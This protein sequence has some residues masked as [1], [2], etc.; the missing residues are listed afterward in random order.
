M[1]APNVFVSIEYT[2]CGNDSIIIN[3]TAY[4]NAGIYYDTISASI[5]CDTVFENII[6]ETPIALDSIEIEACPNS[7]ITYHN[8]TIAAGNSAT[9]TVENL[10]GCDSLITVTVVPTLVYSENIQADVCKG[11][12]FYFDGIIIPPNISTDIEYTSSEGC[13]SIVTVYVEEIIP[14]N[15]DLLGED[16]ILCTNEFT[17]FSDYD[18]IVWHDGSNLNHYTIYNSGTYFATAIDSF[19]CKIRDTIHVEFS[20]NSIYVPNAFSPND[21]GVNDCFQPYFSNDI[22]LQEYSFKIFNRWGDYVFETENP[23][24]CWDGK[25]KDKFLNPGV[26]AWVMEGYNMECNKYELL[27]GDVTLIK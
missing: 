21:D 13:D 9:V 14:N 7:V 6:S 26:Y 23:N 15:F 10:V 20:N 18:S 17:F 1:A 2:L 4:F 22:I 27:K 25:F 11:E 8:E 19:G 16:L 3:N 12:L 5:G 24:E